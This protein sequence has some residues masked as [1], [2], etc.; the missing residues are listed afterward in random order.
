MNAIVRFA[1]LPEPGEWLANHRLAV[2]MPAKDEVA[3]IADVVTS[4]S[5]L[6]PSLPVIVVD[7]A[8]EDDTAR[9]AEKNGAIVLRLPVALGAWG[10]IQTG[11]RYALHLGYDTVVTM[12]ADGQHMAEEIPKLL[13]IK[14]RE[15]SDVVI[16]AFPER[17]SPARRLA[18][19]FFRLLS[20]FSL[21]DLTSGFRVYGR[22]AL[23]MLASPRATLLEYQDLGV[24]LMVRFAGL[25]ISETPVRMRPRLAGKSRVFSSWW[26]VSIYL[27]QTVLLLLSFVHQRRRFRA[28]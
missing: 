18:W 5:R 16:G 20:G 28:K 19:R 11:M 26:Q 17:G 2:I 12:D 14:C 21:A 15:A 27:A 4:L 13:E 22:Q 24:L 8:S 10:A 3:V 23:W 1:E 25:K 6:Y 9:I 7:D